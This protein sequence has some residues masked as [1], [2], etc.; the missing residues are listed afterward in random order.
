MQTFAFETLVKALRKIDPA[1]HQL[2]LAK[3]LSAIMGVPG[4]G[5]LPTRTLAELLFAMIESFDDPKKLLDAQNVMIFATR[6]LEGRSSAENYQSD[7]RRYV[8]KEI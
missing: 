3:S 1:L 6:Q 5:Q 8:E 2:F 4:L 7:Q